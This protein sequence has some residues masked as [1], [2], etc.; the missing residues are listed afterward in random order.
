MKT[1]RFPWSS[2]PNRTLDPKHLNENFRKGADYIRDTLELQ[3]CYST[4]FYNLEGAQALEPVW[5]SFPTNP[6][7]SIFA[8]MAPT[9]GNVEIVGAELT[10]TGLNDATKK[11]VYIQW[12]GP[13][14]LADIPVATLAAP[15]QPVP[16][17]VKLPEGGPTEAWRYVEAKYDEKTTVAQDISQR[18]LNLTLDPPMGIY[19]F[20]VRTDGPTFQ[21]GQDSSL[22]LWF[23]TKRNVNPVFDL[24]DMFNGTWTADAVK[25]NIINAQLDTKREEAVIP[26]NNISLRGEC[27]VVNGVPVGVNEIAQKMYA[28]IPSI[29]TN[30]G[31]GEYLHSYHMQFISDAN[32]FSQN[33]AIKDVSTRLVEVSSATSV[34][35][36]TTR[37]DAPLAT[38]FLPNIK[39]VYRVVSGGAFG[40]PAN[41]ADTTGPTTAPEQPNDDWYLEATSA[42]NPS[43]E[44]MTRVIIYFWYANATN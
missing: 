15:A 20:A 5:D 21:I 3:Y 8:I 13:D 6:E 42:A 30:S 10:V 39:T 26:P 11:N 22:K 25:F 33:A 14:E 23:R 40:L 35:A 41:L 43:D 27:Y 28:R 4:M 12:I 9:T 38:P 37:L 34:G 2:R 44:V 17:P 29:N 31:A 16:V 1:A 36:A 7:G 18:R 32:D 24:P 19:A